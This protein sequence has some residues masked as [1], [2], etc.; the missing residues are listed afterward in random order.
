MEDQNFLHRVSI[1]RNIFTSE[2]IVVLYSRD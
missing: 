2:N 1:R